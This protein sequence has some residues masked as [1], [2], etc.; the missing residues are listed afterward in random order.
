MMDGMIRELCM[1]SIFCGAAMSITPEGTVKRVSAILCTAAMLICV[2]SPFKTLDM[3]VYARMKARYRESEARLSADAE[4]LRAR[5]D[6]LVIEEECR[7]YIMDKAADIG[8]ALS[9]ASVA[10][11]WSSDGTWLPHGVKLSAEND[12]AKRAALEDILAAELGI[13]KERIEWVGDE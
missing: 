3:D 2:L 11:R 6:R 8:L 7:A 5:L 12:R 1:L 10:A 4:E 13:S 9:E